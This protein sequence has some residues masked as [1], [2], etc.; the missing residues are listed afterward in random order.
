MEPLRDYFRQEI[1][2]G[3]LCLAARASRYGN[4]NYSVLLVSGRTL[5][6]ARVMSV[7]THTQVTKDEI[8]SYVTSFSSSPRSH[9][10]LQEPWNLVKVGNSGLSESDIIKTIDD[11]LAAI[12]QSKQ[13]Q[14][15]VALANPFSLST[16]A[17][18][19]LVFPTK[20]HHLHTQLS[21][22]TTIGY[23]G[24]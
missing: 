17:A 3:D 15:P 7:A 20:H 19:P 1:N 10:A 22:A 14:Q 11:T 16:V 12:K 18:S 5:K 8:R 21:P 24:P 4:T 2:I 23:K 13:G 6:L 9:G